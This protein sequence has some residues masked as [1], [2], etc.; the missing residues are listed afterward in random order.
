MNL[1]TW[2]MQGS[3]WSTE[4]KWQ[5]GVLN[6]FRS[7]LN[8]GRNADVTCLQEAGRPPDG[9]NARHTYHF[10]VP[11]GRPPDVQLYSFGVTR[12]PRAGVGLNVLFYE[13][14]EAGNRVNLAIA[15]RAQVGLPGVELRWAAAGPVWRPVL[16][17]QLPAPAP[18]GWFFSCHAISPGGADAPGLLQAAAGVAGAGVAWVVAGDFNREPAGPAGLAP[19]PHGSSICPPNGPTYSVLHPVSRYDYAVRSGA[20]VTGQVLD[21]HMSDHKPVEFSF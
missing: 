13:W 2:N 6:V 21:L 3:N 16:G 20:A 5:T 4:Q 10:V 18:A 12:S 19:L 11:A 15:W 8:G 9:W 17:V 14:D 7:L 1:I